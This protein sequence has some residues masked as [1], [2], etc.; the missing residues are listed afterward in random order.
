MPETLVFTSD[1]PPGAHDVDANALSGLLDAAAAQAIDLHSFLLARNGVVL[2]EVYF[3]PYHAQFLHDVRSVA[4]SIMSLLVGMA[5]DDGHLRS[6]DTPMLSFFPGRTTAN[7]DPRKQAIT[8]RH[9]LSMA[10][11]LALSDPDTGAIVNSPDWVQ[12]VLDAPMAAAPGEVFNYSTSNAHLLSAIVGVAAGMSALDFARRRLFEPLGIHDFRWMQDPQGNPAGG[13]GLSLRPRDMLKIGQLVLDGGVWNGER[14]VSESWLRQSTH[15]ETGRYGLMWWIGPGQSPGA[16][17]AA[18]YGGQLIFVRPAERAVA[19]F[20]AGTG[21]PPF[22]VDQLFLEHVAPALT[23]RALG[24]DPAAWSAFAARSAELAAP[25]PEPISPNPALAARISGRRYRLGENWMCW[26]ALTFFFDGEQARLAFELGALRVELPISLDGVLRGTLVAQ[27]GPL[28]DGDALA[29]AGRWADEHTFSMGF[30][31]LGSPEH[32]QLTFT[33]EGDEGASLSMA[34]RD[35][36]TGN[37]RTF[38]GQAS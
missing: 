29:L 10:S 7:P 24:A 33:F 20:T 12:F 31:I 36:L 1:V 26:D 21:G 9:L 22:P 15:A 18:G 11:G 3:H 35:L 8:L 28:A 13:M 25:H 19:V 6:V 37:S 16:Y 14:L 38:A 4:K 30:Y 27:L 23:D 17:Q 2:A 34:M 32:W 5:L